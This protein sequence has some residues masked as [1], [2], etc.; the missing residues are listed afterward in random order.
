MN[1]CD[2]VCMTSI[3]TVVFVS[4]Q[5]FLKYCFLLFSAK[6]ITEQKFG[7]AIFVSRET[8]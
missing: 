8:Q 7:P 1:P 4:M 5:V 6:W 3:V 2:G